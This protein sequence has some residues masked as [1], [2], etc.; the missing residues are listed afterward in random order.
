MSNN[1]DDPRRGEPRAEGAEPDSADRPRDAGYE[2]GYRKPPRHTRFAKGQSGNPH[3]RPRKHKPRPLKLSDAP[4]DIFLEEEAY[5]SI[6]LRENGQ[7]IELPAIQ[8][9]L[10]AAVANA[11]KGNR[12][13]QKYVLEYVA[14]AEEQHF[15]RK[16]HNYRWLEA[17]K[18]DGERA[19]AEHERRGLPPPELLPHPDDI[20]LNPAT[21][22]ARIEGPTTPE[23]VEV[24]EHQVQMRDHALLR[25]AHFSERRRKT[26]TE[27]EKDKICVY[28]LL[29]QMLDLYLP[30][31]YQWR[32]N[33]AV[34]LM[35][36][37]K[38][39]TR[40]ERERRID[41][42]FARLDATKPRPSRVTPEM[43]EGIDRIVQKF[44]TKRGDAPAGRPGPRG[45]G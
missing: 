5:R 36:E 42:E 24:Y 26:S 22:E 14:H 1:P 8:A 41:A 20:V 40:R 13:S 2:V 27:L 7:G 16:M 15:Q 19:F 35:M 21:A 3:G 29:A 45:D 44:F 9:V 34:F 28:M 6:A 25:S 37:Y 43:E 10:R 23:E 11:I 30:R 4:S 31:R 33:D 39:L 18:R 38:G 17:L 12:L 32:E